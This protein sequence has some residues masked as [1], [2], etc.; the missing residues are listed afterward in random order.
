VKL[1]LSHK[2]KN[3]DWSVTGNRAAGG[4]R[5]LHIKGLH[6]SYSLTHIIRVITLRRMRWAGHVACMIVMRNA[7]KIS[8]GNLKGRDYLEDLSV[9]GIY[10]SI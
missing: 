10:I 4:W 8:I 7:Y 5:R 6:K 3:T 9:D 2:G 1:G